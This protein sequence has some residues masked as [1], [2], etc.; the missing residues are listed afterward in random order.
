M[1][2]PIKPAARHFAAAV[3]AEAEKPVEGP[4]LYIA[5]A[6]TAKPLSEA[7]RAAAKRGEWKSRGSVFRGNM[8][9]GW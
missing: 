2:R 3:R 8:R 4:R 7:F 6:G 5:P 1:Y 9:S